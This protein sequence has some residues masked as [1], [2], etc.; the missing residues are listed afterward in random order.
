MLYSQH[1]IC[2]GERV[3][4][5]FQGFWDKNRSP[6]LCQTTRPSDSQKKKKIKSK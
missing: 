3:A 5:S 2:P 6:N 4:E 1:R